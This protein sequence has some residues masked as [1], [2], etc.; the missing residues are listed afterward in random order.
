MLTSFMSARMGFVD[1]LMLRDLISERTSSEGVDSGTIEMDDL[2][3]LWRISLVLFTWRTCV[4][5]EGMWSCSRRARRIRGDA[6]R[7]R[8][9]SNV[10]RVFREEMS[11]PTT[12]QLGKGG[13]W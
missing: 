1:C 9:E 2:V 7:A 11:K 6:V 5:N 10:D 4:M 13:V 3:P 12:R 8:F